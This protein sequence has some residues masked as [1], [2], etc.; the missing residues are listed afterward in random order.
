MIKIF[1]NS[2]PRV[3]LHKYIK[4]INRVSWGFDP[5]GKIRHFIIFN[6]EKDALLFILNEAKYIDRI[7]N[8]D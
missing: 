6:N 7:V 4:Q 3:F 5:N 8:H 2:P 1:L